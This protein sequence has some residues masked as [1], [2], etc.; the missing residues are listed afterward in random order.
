MIEVLLPLALA[1][2]MFS[3]GLGLELRHFK[4]V[5]LRPGILLAGLVSQVV[6]L[7]LIGFSVA[8]LLSLE[9]MHAAGLMILAAC[10]GGATAGLLTRMAG[11]ET[12][13]SITLSVI[14]GALA[15]I[16]VP[17]VVSAGLGFFLG[18][19]YS[20][21]L[22]FTQIILSLLLVTLLPV[23]LGV[24]LRES[25]RCP[26]SVEAAFHRLANL[27][28][29]AMVTYTF[30]ANWGS[31]TTALPSL[32]AACLLLNLAGMSS[33]LLIGALANAEQPTR[34]AMAMECG[35]QNAA[36]GITLALSVIGEPLLA[37]ASVTYALLMNITALLVIAYR[38][39]RMKRLSSEIFSE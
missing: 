37:V 2:I 17:L 27:L 18:A 10:P 6:V 20:L 26:K 7:P 32:G 21:S 22:P 36:L 23:S 30:V 4:R 11:G 34:V 39:Y 29:L 33:G 16:T 38:R 12:A 5:L 31:I 13:L 8:R 25:G 3:L 14:T 28:F 1:L 15:F 35:I 19:S 24:W 9:P